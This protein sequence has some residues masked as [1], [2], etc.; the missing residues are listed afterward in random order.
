MSV[1]AVNTRSRAQELAGRQVL[2][3]VATVHLSAW[4]FVNGLRTDAG[5]PQYG[6][7]DCG[8]NWGG[9]QL[10][11]RRDSE[12]VTLGDRKHNFARKQYV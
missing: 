1:N 12:Y 2:Q 3:R 10:S 7:L 5:R 8:V 9:K 6:R 11:Q 4:H